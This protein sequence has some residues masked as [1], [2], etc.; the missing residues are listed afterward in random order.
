MKGRVL[1]AVALLVALG[2]TRLTAQ[3]PWVVTLKPTMNPLWIGS[4][5]AVWLTIVDPATKDAPR[6]LA[7]YHVAIADF[8]MEVNGTGIIGQFNGPSVWA[9]CAC[10]SA[11][12]GA[13]AV[14]TATYPAKN[15]PEMLRVPGVAFQVKAPFAISKPKGQGEP[16]AC[17]KPASA[18]VQAPPITKPPAPPIQSAPGSPPV[19]TPITVATTKPATMP[20]SAPVPAPV[21]TPKSSTPA[22]VASGPIATP[23]SALPVTPKTPASTPVTSAPPSS[24]TAKR[25]SFNP[26]I[27]GFRFHNDFTNNF[28]GPPINYETSGLCGG[29][30]YTVLDYFNSGRTIP[31][32][33]YRPAN[34]T[35]IQMYLYGRQVTSLVS[36]LDKWAET[37]V[38]P[39]GSRTTEFFNWGLSGR[40]AELKSYID[41]GVPV[42][43]GLKGGE[44]NLSHDHQVLAI[45]YDAGRYTGDLGAYKTDLKIYIFDPNFPTET[46]TLVADPTVNEYHYI[47][48]TGERWRTYFVD[49]KYLPMIPP[50]AANASYAADGLAHELLFEFA[51]GFDDMRGGADH[52]DVTIRLTNNTSQT[53]SNISQGGRWLPQYNETARVILTQPVAATAIQSLEVSTNATGGIGGDNWDMTSVQ[54]VAVGNNISRTL[55]TNRAGP[56][57]FTG[58]RIPFV[59]PVK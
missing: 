47:E 43:L 30:T 27:H 8:D 5:G 26:L 53:Y 11:T 20:T 18:P 33:T 56:F 40:L 4:C 29:M 45:G 34:G 58:A 49:G 24:P 22:P 55:L 32:Q 39:F 19:T 3:A 17:S 9:V 42:T 57:R 2:P 31:D 50:I 16:L 7:G 25:T 10:R 52:V 38:N 37:S 46:M 41:R 23:I 36:T 14:I 44:G 15:L 21:Q 35:N 51:T 6:N 48:Y 54:V 28:L 13:Q 12:V 1:A 59:F